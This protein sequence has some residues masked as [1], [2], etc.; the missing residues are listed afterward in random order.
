MYLY[1]YSR[2]AGAP[3][4]RERERYI[5]ITMQADTYKKNF[6]FIIKTK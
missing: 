5:Y 6:V 2:F 4:V 1:M 3:C